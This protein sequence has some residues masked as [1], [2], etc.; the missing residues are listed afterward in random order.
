M[1]IFY[2]SLNEI[3]QEAVNVAAVGIFL[4]KTL[5]QAYQ[6][7][8]DK[9]L[10]KLD[11]DKNQKSKTPIRK[12]V[13][14]ADE[15]SD[16]S[17]QYPVEIA[18]NRLVAVGKFTFPM[19]FVILKMEE[20]SKVPLILRR[21]FLHTKD[22]VIRVKQKQLN[23]RVSS[24]RMVFLI[25]S[26]MKH[27]YSNDDTCFS[28]DVID[29]MLEEDFDALLDEGSKILNFIEGTHLEDK[30][31]EPLT[32]VELKP[33]PDHMEYTFLEEPSFLPVIISSQLSEQNKDKLIFV[34]KR[35]KQAFAWKITDIPEFNIEIKDKKDT[36]NVVADH[37]SRIDNDETS[38]DDE[39]NDNF[40]SETLMEISTKELL[41]FADFTNYLVGN[42]LPKGMTYQQKNNFFS[43]LKN[44][45][46]EEPRLFKITYP[47]G[48]KL[49]LYQQ[50]MLESLSPL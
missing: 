24:E 11:W 48:L 26:A 3:T 45:F 14:F 49:K 9:V 18:E 20:D 4:Y 46:W 2:H 6:L 41:W 43:D 44:Y 34:F 27:S 10:R 37:L 19:D 7:L 22:T 47:S 29:E 25:D 5:D 28:I 40:P 8:E 39:I 30:I 33:L 15:G 16:R 36:E 32:D 1:K 42:I 12:T 50:T 23:L 31:F 17:F 21:H 35:H 13:A 38:E